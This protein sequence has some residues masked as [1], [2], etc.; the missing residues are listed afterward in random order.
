VTVLAEAWSVLSPAETGNPSHGACASY[1][2]LTPIGQRRIWSL[3]RKSPRATLRIWPLL[4]LRKT[5]R[6]KMLLRRNK[7]LS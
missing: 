1:T 5:A 4:A 2:A 6:Q 3:A 7:R